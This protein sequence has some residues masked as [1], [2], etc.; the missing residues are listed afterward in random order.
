VCLSFE[1]GTAVDPGQLGTAAEVDEFFA[2]LPFL[3]VGQG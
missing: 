3:F 1:R 2:L